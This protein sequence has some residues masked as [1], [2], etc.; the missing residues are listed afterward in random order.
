[1]KNLTIIYLMIITYHCPAQVLKLKDGVSLGKR[2]DF[3]SNCE[4]G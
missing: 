3:I 2:S 4:K 1:M